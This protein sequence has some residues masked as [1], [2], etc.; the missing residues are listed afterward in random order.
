[1]SKS[2]LSCPKVDG[3][4]LKFPLD[5]SLT[6]LRDSALD[7]SSNSSRT[8]IQNCQNTQEY[9]VFRLVTI[10]TNIRERKTFVHLNLVASIK[11]TKISIAP[12]TKL[13]HFSLCTFSSL[14]FLMPSSVERSH[15][16][17]SLQTILPNLF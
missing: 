13:L 6:L 16:H 2:C 15:P 10:Q 5:S 1:M 3:A 8:T 11:L 9:N 7:K 12:L 14:N 17:S 4:R